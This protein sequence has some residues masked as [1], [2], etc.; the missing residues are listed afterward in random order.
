MFKKD[1]E[2]RWKLKNYQKIGILLIIIGIA[3]RIFM[4]IYYYI[5]HLDPGVS[6]GDI[7]INYHTTDSMFTGE[8]IWDI[9]ELEYPPLTLYL[10]VFF[11]FISFDI[12][13]LFVFYAFFLELLISLSFYFVLKRFKIDNIKFVLG[14][15]LV[16]PFLFLNNVFSPITCGYHITDS[17]FYLFLILSLYYY[18]KENKTLFYLFSGFTMSTKWFTLPAAAYFFIKFLYEKDWKE[19]KN[20]VIYLGIPL[21]I[22]LISPIL[23][24]PN[25]LDLYIGW[26]SSAEPS[27]I[28]NP[29][30]YVKII[31]FAAVFFIYLIIRIKKADLLEMTFFSIIVM[32]SIMFWRRT[33]IRYLTPLIL[34]GHLKTNNRI[35][36]IDVDMKLTR[37]HFNVGNHLLTYFLSVLG[38][39]VSIAIILF[40]F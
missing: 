2:G 22:F 6:W 23:Y 9:K 10:L 29:P 40:I 14:I 18:P 31:L 24:L 15:F 21:I 19:L 12:F 5:I 13:E 11:K 36:S 16:N 17:F 20:L 26:L 1:Q 7:M 25:Y 4:L 34:Y 3:I 33:Y 8:W 38:C 37:I 30:L 32:F 27:A 35:F 28:Y 39:I